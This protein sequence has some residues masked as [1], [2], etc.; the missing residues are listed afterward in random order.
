MRAQANLPALA[1]A[2][3]L[4]TTGTVAAVTLGVDALHG[5][6]RDPAD[7]R[8]AGSVAERL[9]SGD[10]P[11]TRRAGVLDGPSIESLNGTALDRLVPAAA[12]RSVRIELDGETILS[13][14]DPAGGVTVRRVV[15]VARPV[16]RER[17][18]DLASTRRVR[19]RNRTGTV[20]LDVDP[21]ANTTVRTIRANRRVLLHDPDGLDGTATVRLPRSD[22]QNLTVAATENATGTVRLTHVRANESDAVLAVTVDD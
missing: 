7:R 2:V 11:L 4:L 3:V 9:V 6:D 15:R 22:R 5:A 12:G 18:I 1:V 20:A 21:G 19:L 14:G 16:E 17:V 13:R 8:V 10:G